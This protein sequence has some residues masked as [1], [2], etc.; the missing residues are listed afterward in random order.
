MPN[1]RISCHVADRIGEI[2]PFIYGHFIE[3]L[4]ECIYG[5]L[6]AEMLVNRKFA[7][8]DQPPGERPSAESYGIPHPWHAVNRG[9]NVR[10]THDNTV[11]YNGLQ[12]QR[13]DLYEAD[14]APHGVSQGGLILQEGRSYV[15][16]LVLSQE[17]L[18]GAARVALS[19]GDAVVAE[20]VFSDIASAWQT[21]I[22]TLVVDRDVDDAQFALTID[23]PGKLWIGAA[24]LMPADHLHGWRR[25]V[26]ELVREI[27]P[28]IIRYPGGNFVSGYRWED[29]IGD[30]DRRPIRYDVAWNVWEPN[31]VG[32]DEFMVLCD[33]L[34]CEPYIS[35]NAGDGSA[36][37]AAAWV[38]YCNG[39]PNTVHGAR[40][41]ANGHPEPYGVKYWGIGNEM[42][43]NWQIG[44]CD[45]E[46]F[47]R[48]HVAFAKAMR[49]V[50]PDTILL[51][52][53]DMPNR[54]GQWLEIVTDIAGEYIDLMTVHHYTRVPEE[55]DEAARNALTVACPQHLADLL[56]ETQRVLDERGPEDHQ[57]NVSFDEWNV[58]HPGV[59]RRQNYALRDGLYAASL[60]NAMQRQCDRVTMA[61][62]AQLVNLLG[63]IE[64]NQVD[65]YGTPLFLAFKL[66]V[67]HC[68]G[69]ALRTR[70]EGE[71]FDVPA[72]ANIPALANVPY[73]DASASLSSTRNCVCLAVVN[74]HQEQ[75]IPAD[76]EIEGADL[77]GTARCWELNGPDMGARNTFDDHDVVALHDR[78]ERTAAASFEVRFPAHSATVIEIDLN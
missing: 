75:A 30:R 15:V 58:V 14:G 9:P 54:P 56:L 51:G 43:G 48:R 67:D 57:I 31:D 38:E 3:H 69:I 6:W 44:H 16:R 39:A 64:T 10:Y 45:P 34:D 26:V 35:V 42:Y 11:Y 7:G 70:V 32:I 71:T 76:I 33:L 65:A 8:H 60:F 77:A 40:R 20:C 36:A 62:V 28:P 23:Q 24:S 27:K 78:G 17:G 41:A 18:G 74:R 52:V 59:G 47:G 63:T 61:N 25:D 50:D 2:H 13:I 5:G 37:E 73:L 49:A 12:S 29:G 22:C 72:A 66:Y 19:A 4:A 46:T 55:F 21:Y 53:G 1:A 68:G